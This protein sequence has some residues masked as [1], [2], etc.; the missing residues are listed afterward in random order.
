MI[1]K[2]FKTTTVLK[3]GNI[4]FNLELTM[5]CKKF[6]AP[7]ADHPIVFLFSKT[8]G[9]WW[10]EWIKAGTLEVNRFKNVALQLFFPIDS[11]LN[12]TLIYFKI[13]W[14]LA[15]LWEHMQKKFEVSWTKIRGACQSGRKAAE[16]HSKNDSP[17][18]YHRHLLKEKDRVHLL[19][20]VTQSIQARKTQLA[21]N[22]ILG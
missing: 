19:R 16:Q 7:A 12:V 14:A 4:T 3:G 1:I 17:L 18:G 8:H 13:T 20:L 6:L 5:R 21:W 2:F 22:H 10:H 9:V 11:L 15:S